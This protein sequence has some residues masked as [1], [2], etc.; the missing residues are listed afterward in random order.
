MS[1]DFKKEF[2]QEVTEELVLESSSRRS[3]LSCSQSTLLSQVI[4]RLPTSVPA[5]RR[6]WGVDGYGGD[7][8]AA[9][10]VLTLIAVDTDTRTRHW[11]KPTL[12]LISS[13]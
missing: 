13:A 10:G 2:F 11:R 9:E 8:V 5:N 4:L 6:D 12:L 7:P 3:V 1:N